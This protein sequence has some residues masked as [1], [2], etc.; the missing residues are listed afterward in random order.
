MK[1]WGCMREIDANGFVE[2]PVMIPVRDLLSKGFIMKE[3]TK[4][5]CK[6]YC[7]DKGF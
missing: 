1:C 2:I 7:V 3:F 5:F 6:T 4:P